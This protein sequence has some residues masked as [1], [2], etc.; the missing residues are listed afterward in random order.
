[1]CSDRILSHVT[2]SLSVGCV[3]RVCVFGV[4]RRSRVAASESC[5]VLTHATRVY[6]DI[7][8]LYI[9]TLKYL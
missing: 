4:Y 3:F 1:M 9:H 7:Y 8:N 6:L 5:G 2:A